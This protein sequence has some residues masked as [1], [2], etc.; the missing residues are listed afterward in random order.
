M[1]RSEQRRAD[2][3]TVADL[4][5]L[6]SNPVADRRAKSEAYDC[7]DLVSGSFSRLD[8]HD[9]VKKRVREPDDASIAV[10]RRIRYAATAMVSVVAIILI[11]WMLFR[12]GMREQSTQLLSDGLKDLRASRSEQALVS[13][14]AAVD[15]SP[16][17]GRAHF[18]RG[19]GLMQ[20]NH[21]ESALDDFRQAL[22]FN[23]PRSLVLPIL[24]LAEYRLH[25]YSQAVEDCTAALKENPASVVAYKV[26]AAC[27]MQL[28]NYE[29]ARADLTQ[30]MDR[31]KTL[32][33]RVVLAGDRGSAGMALR[34]WRA[35]TADFDLAIGIKPDEHLY[36]RRAEAYSED[37]QLAKAIADYS[38]ALIINPHSYDAYTARG[39]CELK[40]NMQGE[41][42]SDFST[43]LTLNAD[44]VEALIRRGELYMSK[45]DWR[46]AVTDLQHAADLE[47]YSKDASDK[48]AVA[49]RNLIKTGRQKLPQASA[50]STIKLPSDMSGLLNLAYR[51]MQD[52]DYGDAAACYSEAIRREPNNRAARKSLAYVCWKDGNAADAAT[53]MQMVSSI[54]PLDANDALFYARCL[55]SS[56][57]GETAIAVL[58]RV[59][60]DNPGFLAAQAELARVYLAKGFPQKATQLCR[61]GL[62]KAKSVADTRM[63]ESLLQ[64]M[65]E[66]RGT[67]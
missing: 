4:D 52:G 55:A 36:V 21:P 41:A 39:I 27:E 56:G 40:L 6:S 30:A 15:A 42:M 65:D 60:D 51:Y 26:R 63:F 10:Q 9:F 45:H 31:S 43:A 47:P 13:F 59:V 16:D 12:S 64:A 35:A 44:G 7:S 54:Q 58:S 14:S 22:K 37:G 34:D 66:G 49:S 53:Q 20:A 62:S 28:N 2:G 5:T 1:L 46:S 67:K 61:D 18:Y 50:Q 3:W 17:S 25:Q 24:A 11:C 48:L 32:S 23:E 57:Q 33:E 8:I 29:N 19:L 38:Q